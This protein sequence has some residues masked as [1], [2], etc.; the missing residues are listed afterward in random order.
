MVAINI[1]NL[2]PSVRQRLKE[3]AAR[4][5]VSMEEEVRRILTQAVSANEPDDLSAL[6]LSTFGRRHGVELELPARTELP[7]EPKLAWP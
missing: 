6:F 7:R 5:G 3:R 1:R 2:D 4:Q